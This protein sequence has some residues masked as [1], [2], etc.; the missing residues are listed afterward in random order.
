M[1]R[2]VI[3]LHM[4]DKGIDLDVPDDIPAG[5]LAKSLQNALNLPGGQEKTFTLGRV[6]NKNIFHFPADMTL[7]DAG[8]MYGEFLDILSLD[9]PSKENVVG[10]FEIQGLSF[11]LSKG[12][13]VV[14]RSAPGN[15]VDIDLTTVDPNRLVS[16]KHAIFEVSLGVI[17]IRDND[18]T[19]G[20]WLNGKKIK[21]GQKY[22]IKSSDEIR[23]GG[24]KGAPARI[25][26]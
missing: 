9:M 22:P 5:I 24:S 16:R 18:S 8:V 17:S 19:N 13:S 14:G 15:K 6:R 7:A 21:P 26:I 12:E 23:F 25:I 20:T 10:H 2:L 4:E 3:S 1:S 11:P